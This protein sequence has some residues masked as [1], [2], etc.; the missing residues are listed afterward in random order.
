HAERLYEETKRFLEDHT[1]SMKKDI[2]DADQDMLTVYVKYWTEYSSGA[3]YLN[4]LYGYLNTQF[5]KKRQANEHENYPSIECNLESNDQQLIEIG[6]MA[7]D[8]WTKVIIEPLKDR[9]VNLL[10]E[11]I[12]RDRINESVNQATIKG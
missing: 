10:L 8:C 12:H 5:V 9:L 1:T 6:E 7:F 11:Q 3:Q 2:S 4:L